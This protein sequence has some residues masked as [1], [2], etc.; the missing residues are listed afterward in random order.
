MQLPSV[1]TL[2]YSQ[3]AHD[4]W[5][6]AL[7]HAC[8]EWG[9][10]QLLNHELGN[11]LCD[12]VLSGMAQF[13]ALPHQ[14]KLHIERTAENPWGFY[15]RELT[16]NVRDWK[17]ILDIGP[18][19][20]SGPFADAQTRW[21]E[22]IE[23]FRDTMEA[24]FTASQ[25]LALTLLA[26]IGECLGAPR[27]TL[28]GEFGAG[29]SSFLRLNYYPPCAEPDQHLGI[30][31]HTDAGALTVLLPDD[32][33]GLQFLRGDDWHTVVAEPGALIINIGD[34]VQVWSNDRYRAPLHRVL[35]SAGHSRYSAPF[36]LNPA[37][38]TFYAPL[39]GALQGKEPIYRPINWGEFRAGR[40]AGDYADVGEEIQISDFRR[41]V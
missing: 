33:P 35:A 7:D 12:G 13:F 6:G 22:Q 5:L 11:E 37:Y 32:H 41:R 20:A 10:F 3:R 1:P 26:D 23:G 9:C 17:E 30:S 16:K 4:S 28:E 8:R 29:H 27:G 38:D 14:D 39:P 19:S 21:P 36:F 40:A 18:S 34:I 2:D 15:D 24:Y 31:H 25:S